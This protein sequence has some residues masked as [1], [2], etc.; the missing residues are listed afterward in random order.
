MKIDQ[1]RI[2]IEDG[3]STFNG[4][5]R[6]VRISNIKHI[7]PKHFL[8]DTFKTFCINIKKSLIEF[9]FL[10]ISATFCGEFVNNLNLALEEKENYKYLTTK[11][12]VIDRYADLEKWY[13]ENV[14]NVILKELEEFQVRMNDF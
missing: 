3:I 5:I 10:K 7:D 13:N 12:T 11:V 9:R 8:N 1:K 2:I 14:I 4:N 6:T